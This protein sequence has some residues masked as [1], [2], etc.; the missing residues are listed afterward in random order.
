MLLGEVIVSG[1]D[2]DPS[3]HRSP[4]GVKPALGQGDEPLAGRALNRDLVVREQ[5]RRIE[6][7]DLCSSHGTPSSLWWIALTAPYGAA[8]G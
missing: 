1:A 4:G 6:V 2:R 7:L 3:E 8:P 5:V